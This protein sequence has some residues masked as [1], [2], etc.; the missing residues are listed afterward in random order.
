VSQV[1]EGR[2]VDAQLFLI[3]LVNFHREHG[4][5]N[6]YPR[7]HIGPDFPGVF[8]SDVRVSGVTYE[9]YVIQVQEEVLELLECL[10]SLM[11]VI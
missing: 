7:D 3:V 5:G 6:C 11:Y 1:V 2:S 8:L 10:H 4:S 9:T